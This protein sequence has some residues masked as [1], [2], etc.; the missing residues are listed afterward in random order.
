MS[1]IEIEPLGF[2]LVSCARLR[3][4]ISTIG[5][6]AHVVCIVT[7]AV[8]FIKSLIILDIRHYINTR[9]DE[10]SDSIKI[11]VNYKNHAIKSLFHTD[12]HAKNKRRIEDREQLEK[13]PPRQ[14]KCAGRNCDGL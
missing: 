5:G 13:L 10:G 6:I 8:W 2:H 1:D 4:A 7:A 3:E 12:K 14:A 11:M 9:I